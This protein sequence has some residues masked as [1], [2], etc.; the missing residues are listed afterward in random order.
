MDPKD[1]VRNFHSELW[2]NGDLGAIDRFVASDA[3]TAMTG[4]VGTAVDVLRQDVERYQ[5]G[6]ADVQTEI[7][8]MLG[9]ADRVVMW[10]RTI[11]THVGPYGGIA[12][13]AT[14][15]RITMEGVDL[16]TV[17]DD[18]IVAICSFWDAAAVYRQFG[19]LPEGL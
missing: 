14:G 13:I 6:F 18:R 5:A 3:T 2:E 7:V 9:E 15:R 17:V 16:F 8:Q 10:W 12:P 19:L 4:F 11:G 1:I